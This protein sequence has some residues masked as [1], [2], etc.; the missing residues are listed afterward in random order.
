M[1]QAKVKTQ[2]EMTPKKVD[3]LTQNP[4]SARKPMAKED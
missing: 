1:Q 2:E 4:L 3:P